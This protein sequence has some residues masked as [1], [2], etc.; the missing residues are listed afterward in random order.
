MSSAARFRSRCRSNDVIRDGADERSDYR[1]IRS[2][3]WYLPI[4]FLMPAVS[5]VSY[6]FMRARDVPLSVPHV[7][8]LSL[9]LIF[10]GFFVGAIGEEVGWAAGGIAWWSL[11]TVDARILMVWIY[12]HTGRS[13]FAVVLF[14]ATQNLSWQFFPNGVS[15]WDPR[16]NALILCAWSCSAS[17]SPAY[18][19]TRG[20]ER[21]ESRVVMRAIMS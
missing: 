14:H 18:S 1:R 5:V 7:S 16:L 17:A 9:V 19:A 12:E 20:A 8:V 11:G 10:V 13:V 2:K 21:R 6:G 3:V 15:S 4:V